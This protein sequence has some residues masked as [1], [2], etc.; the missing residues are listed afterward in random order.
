MKTSKWVL[1]H[2]IHWAMLW[3][4]FGADIQGAVYT[5]KFW[6]WVCAAFGVYQ[7]SDQSV[8]SAATRPEQAAWKTSLGWL[9][10]WVTL[11]VL[12]WFGHFASA[13][14]LGWVMAVVN[15]Q[16]ERVAALRSSGNTTQAS[17][18]QSA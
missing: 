1:V 16:A 8:Q 18:E 7:L 6:V 17:K 13:L 11:S 9:Q 12:V 2:L 4:A 14:A 10:A 5:I 3:A 15:W